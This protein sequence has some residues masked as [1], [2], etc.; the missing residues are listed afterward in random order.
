MYGCSETHQQSSPYGS[1]LLPF[2]HF[3]LHA[4]Q[5]LTPVFRGLRLSKSPSMSLLDGSCNS[6]HGEPDMCWTTVLSFPL[7]GR[8]YDCLIFHLVVTFQH[9][10]FH[11]VLTVAYCNNLWAENESV[12]T[13][14]SFT[15]GLSFPRYPQRKPRTVLVKE[16]RDTHSQVLAISYPTCRCYKLNVK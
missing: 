5:A 10:I 8:W 11:S 9:R 3:F 6:C 4:T 7:A 1:P 14:D 2:A 16:G 15:E 13:F 12:R